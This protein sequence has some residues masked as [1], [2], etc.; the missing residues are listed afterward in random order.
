MLAS[1]LH[2]EWDA[3]TAEAQVTAQ[4]TSPIVGTLEV[5]TPSLY[6]PF[7]LEFDPG[8]DETV[9]V[10]SGVLEREGVRVDEELGDGEVYLWR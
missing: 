3:A 5:Q 9:E 4:V 10:T 1:S 2:E 7:D 6:K 8:V